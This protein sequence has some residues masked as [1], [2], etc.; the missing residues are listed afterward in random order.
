MCNASATSVTNR[1]SDFLCAMSRSSVLVFVQFA[2]IAFFFLTGSIWAHSP[3]GLA[4]EGLG[5]GLGVWAIVVM[6]WSQLSVFPE[7]RSDGKLLKTGPYRILRHPMYTAVLLVCG[8]L[9][10]DRLD[11]AGFAVYALLVFNQL[12]KLRFEE[13]LL[14]KHYGEGYATYME[15][16]YAIL[17]Y[18]Y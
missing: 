17:P 13:K 10:F 15:E 18:I 16:T 14:L 2:C 9:A 5:I 12:M 4:I 6:K 11:E 8:S 3:L 1:L 7:P